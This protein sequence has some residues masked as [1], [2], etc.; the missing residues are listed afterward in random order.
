MSSGLVPT[1]E[2][3]EQIDLETAFPRSAEDLL[4]MKLGENKILSNLRF[5]TRQ[6]GA[7]CSK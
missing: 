2:T 7:S 5:C 3:E 6:S 1:D 4:A